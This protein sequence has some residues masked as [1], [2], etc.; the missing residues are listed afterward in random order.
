MTTQPPYL[1][2]SNFCLFNYSHYDSDFPDIP[3]MVRA[4]VQKISMSKRLVLETWCRENGKTFAEKIFLVILPTDFNYEE[5]SQETWSYL[6][7]LL[8]QIDALE[9]HSSNISV[10]STKLKLIGATEHFSKSEIGYVNPND[11]F[12][13]RKREATALFL[14]LIRVNAFL[15]IQ[16]SCLD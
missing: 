1:Y 10:N 5:Y 7:S 14:S 2:E 16:S 3:F 15:Y 13:E 6:M 8:T 4:V 9:N 12:K 11:L